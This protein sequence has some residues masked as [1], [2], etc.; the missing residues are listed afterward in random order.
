M[1]HITSLWGR[2]LAMN[3]RIV[4]LANDSP[5]NNII[6]ITNNNDDDNDCDDN[7]TGSSSSSI[8]VLTKDVSFYY[9]NRCGIIENVTIQ[10]ID[11]I[12]KIILLSDERI[13]CFTEL[14]IV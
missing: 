10:E 11:V 12:N 8:H 2:I 6:V 14:Y 3:N 5:Q 7:N 13:L 1:V 4:Q 9:T